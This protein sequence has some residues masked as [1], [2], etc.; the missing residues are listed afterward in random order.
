MTVLETLI[1]RNAE[2]ASHRF[3]A[4]LKINPTLKTMVICCVDPRVDPTAVLG[5]ELGEAAV[6]RNVGGRVTPATLKTMAMLGR[7]GQANGGGPGVGWNLVVLHHTDCG[8][9]DLAAFPDL[10]AEYFEIP[11]DQLEAK[12]VSDP[13]ASVKVDVAVLKQTPFLPGSFLVSGLV[14]DVG[15]GLIETTVAPALLRPA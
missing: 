5:L 4:D 1:A 3:S 2:F 15:T 8:M 11:K 12:A 9:T 6:V 7:V 10:L 13:I 14:Y